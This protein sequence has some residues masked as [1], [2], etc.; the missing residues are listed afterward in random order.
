[1][2]TTVAVA[3]KGA[4]MAGWMYLLGLVAGVAAVLIGDRRIDRGV[5]VKASAPALSFA[6]TH[7]DEAAHDPGLPRP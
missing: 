6:P 1:M 2:G 3:G 5:P 7:P 4:T